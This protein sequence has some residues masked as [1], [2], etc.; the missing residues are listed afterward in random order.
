MLFLLALP[1]AVGVSPLER[2]VGNWSACPRFYEAPWEGVNGSQ[3]DLPR[4][5]A[6]D[7]RVDRE[8]V[9]KDAM[10]PIF[11]RMHASPCHTAWQSPTQVKLINFERILETRL[12]EAK[13][14]ILTDVSLGPGNT[15]WFV[16][17][18]TKRLCLAARVVGQLESGGARGRVIVVRGKTI[19]VDNCFEPFMMRINKRLC[20]MR[21]VCSATLN[22]YLFPLAFDPNYGSS[23]NIFL[24]DDVAL[25]AWPSVAV[26]QARRSPLV[27]LGYRHSVGSHMLGVWRD[28]IPLL[29]GFI[30][31]FNFAPLD[32]YYLRNCLDPPRAPWSLATTFAHPSVQRDGTVTVDEA[33]RGHSESCT[34]DKH[35]SRWTRS[36]SQHESSTQHQPLL[37]PNRRRR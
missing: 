23:I 37:P 2:R 6:A 11:D 5:V 4:S 20:T 14:R 31:P 24:E 34:F 8:A 3:W 28:A 22:E 15:T 7:L 35:H 1:V 12:E 18:T 10:Q 25:C 9:A 32:L 26:E 19:G 16:Y 29:V 33:E 36:A 17:T 13:T 30:Q 27:W 21:D